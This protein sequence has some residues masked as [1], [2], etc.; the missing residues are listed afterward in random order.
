VT[1]MRAAS[2]M[3]AFG[4][5]ASA[6]L[7]A[8]VRKTISERKTALEGKEKAPLVLVAGMSDTS[9]S[10]VGDNHRDDPARML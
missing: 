4:D 3:L 1:A 6:M 2:S 5:A 9:V 10:S 8:A 7:V